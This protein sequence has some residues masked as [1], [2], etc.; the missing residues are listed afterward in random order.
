VGLLS[1]LRRPGAAH[2]ELAIEPSR[3]RRGEEVLVRARLS[4]PDALKGELFAGLRCRRNQR[5]TGATPSGAT[6]SDPLFETYDRH[7][8]HAEWRPLEGSGPW[9]LRFTVPQDAPLSK[10]GRGRHSWR[11]ELRERRAGAKDARTHR[12]L[13]VR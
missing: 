11:V 8:V 9:E 12:S 10:D 7:E 5:R 1:R 6:I 2:L 4:D 13:L 3:L